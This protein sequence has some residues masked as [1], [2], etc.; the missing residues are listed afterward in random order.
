MLKLD[1]KTLMNL[2]IYYI[3]YATQKPEHKI[4]SETPLYLMIKRIDGFIEEKNG[5]K[6][7]NIASTDRNSEV[8]R[9]YSKVWNGIKDCIEK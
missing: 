9:K 2:G 8:L 6:Y 7:L 5:D 1:Q 4:N 3:G